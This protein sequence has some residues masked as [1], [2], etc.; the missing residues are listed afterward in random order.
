MR[1]AFLDLCHAVAETHPS[2]TRLKFNGQSN[3]IDSRKLV[4]R[5]AT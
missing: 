5:R 3:F 2:Y 4:D 1:F